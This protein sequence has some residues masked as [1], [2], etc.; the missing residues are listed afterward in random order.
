MNTQTNNGEGGLEVKKLLL[1]TFLAVLAVLAPHVI[2]AD[3]TYDYESITV[4]TSA[5]TG[6]TA[7]QLAPADYSAKPK[8]AFVTVETDSV[9]FRIDGT[10]AT[11]AVGH[12]VSAGDSFTL[13]NY[14]DL[15]NFSVYGSGSG[16][17]T[18][19]VSYQR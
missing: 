12:Q 16:S 18:L 19:R 4:T 2:K 8:A 15:A 17:A 5:A 14:R 7:A 13:T 1:F 11:G 3:E 9:R 6:F 10:A